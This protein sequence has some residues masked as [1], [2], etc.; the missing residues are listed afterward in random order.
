MPADNRANSKQKLFLLFLSLAVIVILFVLVVFIGSM[1]FIGPA[2]SDPSPSPSPYAGH[3]ERQPYAD[4]A[5]VDDVVRQSLLRALDSVM[6]S[7]TAINWTTY[8]PD[9]TL[10]NAH[11]SIADPGGRSQN[12]DVVCI[13]GDS[14]MLASVQEG[15]VATMSI[16]S[17]DATV[18]ENDDESMPG[19]QSQVTNDPGVAG[20]RGY[21]LKKPVDS[22]I[23]MNVVL[24]AHSMDLSPENTFVA[25]DYDGSNGVYTVHYVDPADPVLS[26][27]ERLSGD[28][29]NLLSI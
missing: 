3:V 12:W 22:T 23:I 7:D 29:G 6:A 24:A 11:T 17:I 21:A 20:R 15:V 27:T 26:F 10:L 2:A 1:K 18:P 8:H 13:S 28:T 5:T 14:A 19:D 25:I 4:T 9:W 16:T